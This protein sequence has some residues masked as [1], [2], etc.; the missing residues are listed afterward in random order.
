MTVDKQIV[1]LKRMLERWKKESERFFARP[2]NA[3]YEPN[4]DVSHIW[5]NFEGAVE[6][7]N[8][9]LLDYEEVQA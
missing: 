2:E 6:T 4:G 8:D 1:N 9:I 7:V 5:A 3:N